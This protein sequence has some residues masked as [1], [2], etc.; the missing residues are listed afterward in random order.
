[1][2]TTP[3]QQAKAEGLKY[4][5][6]DVPCKRGHM[7]MRLTSTGDCIECKRL[8]NEQ[9]YQQHRNEHLQNCKKNYHASRQSRLDVMKKYRETHKEEV[10]QANQDWYVK[11]RKVVLQQVKRRYIDNIEQKR[12]YGKQYYQAHKQQRLP[13]YKQHSRIRRARVLHAQ[14]KW[15]N[16]KDIRRI[17]EKCH[18][19]NQKWGTNFQVDHIIPL[20]SPHVCGLHDEFNLQLLDA[21]LNQSKGNRW[22]LSNSGDET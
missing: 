8:H 12:A 11:N 7:V 2:S 15:A 18:E 17:Y 20:K 6:S 16:K 10:S 3:R 14:P 1:M 22:D 13:Y 9:R 21:S 5:S 19:L 4:Y